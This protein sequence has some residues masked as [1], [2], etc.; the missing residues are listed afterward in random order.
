[1][2]IPLNSMRHYRTIWPLASIF[3]TVALQDIA[4]LIAFTEQD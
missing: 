3:L 4:R 2:G 1:M